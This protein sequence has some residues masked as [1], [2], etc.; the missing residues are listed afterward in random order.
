M[1]RCFRRIRPIFKSETLHEEKEGM[2]V[3]SGPNGGNNS[4]AAVEDVI[5]YVFDA[6]DV[7]HAGQVDFWEFACG[8]SVSFARAS[9]AIRLHAVCFY[10]NATARSCI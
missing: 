1:H 5:N 6:L 8:L 4:V 3:E 2:G 9:V 7:N 10:A